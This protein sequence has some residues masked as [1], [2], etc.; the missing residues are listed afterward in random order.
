[1]NSPCLNETGD[2]ART[3]NC[4]GVVSAPSAC[5][6]GSRVTMSAAC[7]VQLFC[8]HAVWSCDGLFFQGSLAWVLYCAVVLLLASRASFSSSSV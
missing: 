7:W 5:M 2:G 3:C 8:S 1:M 6:C 4:K